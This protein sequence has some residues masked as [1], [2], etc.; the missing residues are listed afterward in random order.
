[1]LNHDMKINLS[2]L[3]PDTTVKKIKYDADDIQKNIQKI[4]IVEELQDD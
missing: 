1:M 3:F 2:I 4:G